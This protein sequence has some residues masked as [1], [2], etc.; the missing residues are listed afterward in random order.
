MDPRGSTDMSPSGTCSLAKDTS[1]LH[2]YALPHLVMTL[3]FGRPVH[4]DTHE[5]DLTEHAA[6]AAVT[7]D[8]DVTD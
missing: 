2:S 7:A 1:L 3:E 4:Y 5:L 8:D 6:A